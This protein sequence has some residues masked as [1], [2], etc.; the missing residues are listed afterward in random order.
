[1]KVDTVLC[2]VHCIVFMHLVVDSSFLKKKK[3][4]TV[5]S[6]ETTLTKS[7]DSNMGLTHFCC[8][9]QFLSL[10][11]VLHDGIEGQVNYHQVSS[12]ACL[13]SLVALSRAAP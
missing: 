6:A 1:M 4:E 12:W 10:I 7:Q 2:E 9:D 3:K 11:C 5:S 8:L 13:Q